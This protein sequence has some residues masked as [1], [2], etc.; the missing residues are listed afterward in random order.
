MK[1]LSFL[2][3][4]LLAFSLLFFSSCKKEEE[5]SIRDKVIGT[6]I[7]QTITS[8]EYEGNTFVGSETDAISG[9]TVEFKGNDTF[10]SQFKDEDG[11]ID[12][13]TGIWKLE[14]SNLVIDEDGDRETLKI[15]EITEKKMVLVIEEEFEE[16]GITYRYVNELILVK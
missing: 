12:T 9:A 13:D 1:H 6:W 5:L 3:L 7:Y 4:A 8:T 14:G 10:V 11:S 15:Q 2:S 16:D